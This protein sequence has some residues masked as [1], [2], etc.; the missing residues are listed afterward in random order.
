[1]SAERHSP[2]WSRETSHPGGII[3]RQP[4]SDLATPCIDHYLGGCFEARENALGEAKRKLADTRAS[5]LQ[6]LEKWSFPTSDWEI[7]TVIEISQ[8]PAVRVTRYPD[9]VLAYMRMPPRE[10][11]KNARFMQDNDPEKR[12]KQVTGWWPQEGQ[13]VLHSVVDQHGEYVCVTPTPLHSEQTFDFIPDDKIE[14]RDEGD[15]RVA[16][17]DGVAIG[18]GVRSDPPKMIAEMKAIRD[19]L[20]SG[21]NPYKAVQKR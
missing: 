13:Y 10:C 9:E 17:R 2:E 5:F 6:E 7:K 18:P 15:Y 19:R 1:M 14:W 21:M 16:Y 4:P 20:M 11:H 8:L 12:L 3:S